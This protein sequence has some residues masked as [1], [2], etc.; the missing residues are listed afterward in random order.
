MKTKITFISLLFMFIIGTWVIP[1]KASAQ[2]RYVSYQVFYDELSPYGF[3]VNSPEYGYVWVPNVDAGFTPYATNGYWAYTVEGWTWVSYFSW[4]WA[5]FHYGR[6]YTDAIYGPMW[7]PGNEWGPGWVTWRRSADYYGWSAMEPGVSNNVAYGRNY[8]PPH[9]HWTI[10]KGSDFGRTNINNYYVNSSN[11][12]EIINNSVVINNVWTDKTHNVKYNA[13]PDKGDVE[14]H[15]GKT[16]TPVSIK[17]SNKPGQTMANNQLQIYRP[18]VQK[19]STTG[20]KSAPSK[21]ANLKDVKAIKQRT[22]GT[23]NQKINQPAKQNFSSPK[24]TVQPTKQKPAQSIPTKKVEPVNRPAQSIAPKRAE[25]T[26]QF[27]QP[28]PLKEEVKQP[29]QSIP[30][31]NKEENKH[32]H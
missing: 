22:T 29:K 2:G 10:L 15:I 5:P 20:V 27:K 3:W 14:K 26:P 16:I 9:N 8:Y 32:P 21:V 28:K 12:T 1:Q 6:W 19:N 30:V 23:S 11:N 4:G 13:G 31:Q 25:P 18:Q 7:I 24:Q 17:E